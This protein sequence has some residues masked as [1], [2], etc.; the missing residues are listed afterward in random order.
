MVSSMCAPRSAPAPGLASISR[1]SRTVKRRIGGLACGIWLGV[2]AAAG[3]TLN[4]VGSID[5]PLRYHPEGTDFVIEN[6]AEFFNRP[7][8]TNTAFRVDGGDKPEFSLYLPGRGG[9]LRLGVKT[10]GG[11]RWLDEAATIVTRYRPGSLLYEISDPAFAGRTLRVAA[12]VL[13]TGQ[14]LIV[15]VALA[16]SGA[17]LELFWGYGGMNGDRGSRDGDIGTEREP[18]GRFFQLR[19]EYCR[20]NLLAHGP[21]G[22]ALNSRFAY[23]HEVAS[24]G[25]AYAAGDAAQWS[26]AADFLA[27]IRRLAEPPPILPVAAGTFSLAP[28]AEPFL[29]ALQRIPR[30]QDDHNELSTYLKVRSEKP[31]PL[32]PPAPGAE[33][34]LAAADLPPLFTAA[35]DRR[36]AIAGKISVDT[37]DPYLN[38]AAAAVCVAADGVWDEATGTVQH[39]A[40]AW[41]AKLL[42]WRGPYA[43]DELGWHDR[44]RR[45]F[46]YWAARQNTDPIPAELPPADAS[47]NLARSE[48]ALHSNGDLS[49]SHY[50]MNL[51]YI[52]ALFRHLLWTGDVAYARQV[53]PVIVRH[54]AWERRLFRREFGPERLPL[55]EGYADFWASDDV[56]YEGG[57]STEATAYNYY[58]NTMAAKVARLVGADPV[59]YERE[60]ALI[61]RG[62]H[63]ELWLPRRGWFAESK[64]LLGRQAVHQSPALWT[65]YHTID[66]GAATPA[67]ADRM[68]DFVDNEIA[69][70]PV[71][72]PGVPLGGW[73]TLPTTNWMPYTW[74][75]N[76]VVMAEVAHTALAYWQAGRGDQAYLMFK[77]SILDSMYLGLCPGN[78][79]MTTHYDMARGETQRDFA[80]AAGM[81]SRA[82]VEGL[83]GV[84][85]DALAGELTVRPGFPADWDHAALH[86]PDFDFSFRR[87]GLAETYVVEPRFARAMSLRLQLPPAGSSVASVTVNGRPAAWQPWGAGGGRRGIEIIPPVELRYDIVVRWQGSAPDILRDHAINLLERASAPFVPPP[88]GAHYDSVDLA[89]VFNDRV[90]R[91][92]QHAYLSPRSP[93][94]SLSIPTQGIGTWCRPTANATINDAGLRSAAGRH[95]GNFLLPDGLPFATPGPGAANNV[96]FTSQ[97]DNFPRSVTVPLQGRA[98][99][100]YLLMAGS[101]N[102]MQSRLDNGE[103]VV[104]YADG[105]SERL[106]LENPSNWWPIDE[107]YWIDDYAFRRP[108]PIPPRVDLETGAVRFLEAAAFKGRG[109]KVPGGAASVLDLPLQPDREL[110]SLTV[111]TLANEVV[112]GLMA[113][114]LVR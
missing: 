99:H 61:W 13:P 92:F 73:F 60:A 114:T 51:V 68:T 80:D 35:E 46:T 5:R 74:S 2:S 58:H 27:G 107:D 104:T 65:F 93:Y 48:A 94:A 86:H 8:Y 78:L 106:A 20:G 31:D 44:A 50:D 87:D 37:P 108:G 76:N 56:E 77:G 62:L 7:L 1:R 83:F 102:P 38:A 52:D 3:G 66:S 69:H 113:A 90:T 41:R 88:A 70:I 19:P 11:A 82:L 55:Y 21:G 54:L 16:G 40:V 72:G 30:P 71:Q 85:P 42:G 26:S 18:V 9:V 22:F 15:Q 75:T 23:I 33:T 53:W 110:R 79:G 64:D 12:L 112:V 39:G 111:G 34:P 96:V 45:H 97:W 91:I 43:N 100:I 36:R 59:P 63:E 47:A 24:A 14:G 10:D 89:P 32:P 98:R 57:G 101:T 25:A 84:K 17:P 103:V 29:L 49:N 81:V 109:R 4:L 67:E 95:G 28:G 105:T 6:G